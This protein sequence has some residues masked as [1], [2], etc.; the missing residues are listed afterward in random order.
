MLVRPPLSVVPMTHGIVYLVFAP[1]MVTTPL[2]GRAVERI[3]APAAFR[4]AIAVAAAGLPLLLAGSIASVLAGMALIAAGTFFAQAIATGYVGR[5][6]LT[7][8]A[9]ARGLYL[10]AYY[11]GGLVGAALLGQVFD[12][13]GWPS[14]VIAIGLALAFAAALSAFLQDGE[15]MIDKHMPP[16]PER[17]SLANHS[18]QLSTEA[19]KSLVQAR[20]YR[21]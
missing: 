11:F 12:R 20:R 15:R 21:L 4:W 17:A 3:G 14:C 5:A 10:S 7:D 1:A 6:A 9:A 13:F 18:I 8:R 16:A 2:A 19:P